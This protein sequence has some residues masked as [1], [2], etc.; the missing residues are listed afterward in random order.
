MAG[1]TKN[2]VS[3]SS[4][5]TNA[6]ISIRLKSRDDLERGRSI[7]NIVAALADRGTDDCRNYKAIALKFRIGGGF[8]KCNRD[9]ATATVP[10][11]DKPQAGLTRMM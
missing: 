1:E 8:E 2:A 4:T 6:L 5:L 7:D 9:F 3:A 11:E 10:C